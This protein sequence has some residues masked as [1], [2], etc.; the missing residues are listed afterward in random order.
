VQLDDT[1][2]SWVQPLNL[3]HSQIKM[4]WLARQGSSN[5]RILDCAPSH[6]AGFMTVNEYTTI[7]AVIFALSVPFL[8]PMDGTLKWTITYSNGPKEYTLGPYGNSLSATAQGLHTAA[9]DNIKWWLNKQLI[10]AGFSVTC[11]PRS[12]FVPVINA[13][14]PV[15]QGALPRTHTQTAARKKF[16]NLTNKQFARLV[17]DFIIELEGQQSLMDVKT[18]NICPSNYSNTKEV[19][20]I[21]GAA[22]QRYQRN[23]HTDCV[24][25]TKEIDHEYNN[26]A[27]IDGK[28]QVGKCTRLLCGFGNVLG[29]CVGG[30]T[31]RSSHLEKLICAIAEKR[32]GKI[33][34]LSGYQ[35]ASECAGVLKYRMQTELFVESASGIAR[36]LLSAAG[37]RLNPRAHANRAAKWGSRKWETER[38]RRVLENDRTKRNGGGLTF[39]HHNRNVISF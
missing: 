39:S 16:Q 14:A 23:V 30:F 18:L 11:E 13:A 36:K 25:H 29:L 9:H 3:E 32:A 15:E 19:S 1:I 10:K 26:V 12:I 31:E 20:N 6:D 28:L 4:A 17:P 37:Q 21:K 27:K 33:W 34:R 5:G 38:E 35:S 24:R 2:M 22:V 7:F 8:R